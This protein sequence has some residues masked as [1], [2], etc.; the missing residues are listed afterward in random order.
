MNPIASPS[1]VTVGYGSYP[2]SHSKIKWLIACS[3]YLGCSSKGSFHCMLTASPGGQFYLAVSTSAF[4]VSRG[5]ELSPWIRVPGIG[6]CRNGSC[7]PE[8]ALNW[9]NA[10]T[11]RRR[12][13]ER[14][15]IGL[16]RCWA[17]RRCFNCLRDIG[18]ASYT[19]K[20]VGV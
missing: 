16:R 15:V 7:L 17:Q 8:F 12:T 19:D 13:P 10:L 1:S 20:L 3:S 4:G 14:F 5:S 18:L 2:F 11:S 9:R 6:L